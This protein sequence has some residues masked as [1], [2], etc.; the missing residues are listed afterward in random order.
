MDEVYFSGESDDDGQIGETLEQSQL[1][2]NMSQ[3]DTLNHRESI[4]KY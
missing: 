4:F 1:F 3:H 2:R